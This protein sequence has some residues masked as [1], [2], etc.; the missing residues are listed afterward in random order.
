MARYK[1]TLSQCLYDNEGNLIVRYGKNIPPQITV[2][3]E[4]ATHAIKKLKRDLEITDDM[5]NTLRI[6]SAEEIL[7]DDES[8]DYENKSFND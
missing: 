7:Q 5:I 4:S 6:S 2:Y 8:E 3:A 1:I